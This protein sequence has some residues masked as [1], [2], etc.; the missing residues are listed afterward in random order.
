M[1]RP[2]A[3]RRRGQ[4]NSPAIRE[5]AGVQGKNRKDLR[6]IAR[7]AAMG[8]QGNLVAG[9]GFLPENIVG[10]TPAQNEGQPKI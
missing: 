9:Q 1:S 3:E 4:T 5:I 6:R 2:D 8:Q 10:G 7:Y